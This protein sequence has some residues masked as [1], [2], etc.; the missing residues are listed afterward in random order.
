MEGISCNLVERFSRWKWMQFVGLWDAFEFHRFLRV[1][2]WPHIFLFGC[3]Q[4]EE[5]EAEDIPQSSRMGN[6]QTYTTRIVLVMHY[7]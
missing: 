4:T 7:Q 3:K 6:H 1:E 5:P 2:Q